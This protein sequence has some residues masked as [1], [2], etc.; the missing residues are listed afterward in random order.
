MYKTIIYI[1]ISI[2]FTLT[3]CSENN[4]NKNHI[5]VSI[6]PQKKIVTRLLPDNY[7]V[8][9]MVTKGNSPATYSPS[10]SQIKDINLASLYIQIGNI[11]FEKA[12]IERFEELNPKLTIEDSSEGIDF[13]HGEDYIH[14]DHV[15]EG[16]IE[17][18]IW[19]SPK[20]MLKVLLNTKNILQ[21]HYP[22]INDEIEFNSKP[23]IDSLL[24]IDSL[25][26][27]DLA[28]LKAK[29]FLIF[30]PA[31]TY[32]ARDYGINQIS[33]EHNGKEPS[34]KW[35]QTIINTA[36]QQNIKSIFVQ[37]EFDKRNAEIIAKE[38]NIKIIEVSPLNENYEKEMK[39]LL[40]KLKSNI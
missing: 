3:S 23:L 16:G 24:H 34:A 17:P 1:L 9:T 30:H 28:D 31:Y 6:L 32:L 8:T 22:E 18:H 5:V 27:L 21:K 20:T 26:R 11:G 33:I 40:D 19:T 2:L 29:N 35:L 37:Q 39:E 14:G 10:P 12:W 7:T 38:L 13:I 4:I 25:Y 36:K 15:H